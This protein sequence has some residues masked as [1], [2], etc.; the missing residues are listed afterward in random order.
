MLE[1][2]KSD[3]ANSV[4]CLR[5][6]LIFSCMWH[7]VYTYGVISLVDNFIQILLGV[8]LLLALRR[9][10]CIVVIILIVIKLS[11]VTQS[12]HCIDRMW[13]LTGTQMQGALLSPEQFVLS[14]HRNNPF[15]LLTESAVSSSIFRLYIRTSSSSNKNL[16]KHP[17]CMSWVLFHIIV[18]KKKIENDTFTLGVCSKIKVT[19]IIHS[20]NISAEIG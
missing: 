7:Q 12:I 9:Q 8:V 15:I 4:H 19:T 16:N 18:H 10:L 13:C 17:D 2:W 14:C 5:Y 11:P 3:V 20:K 6:T 1:L